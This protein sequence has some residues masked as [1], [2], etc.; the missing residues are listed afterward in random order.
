MNA[1]VLVDIPPST[2][3]QAKVIFY[4]NSPVSCS[5]NSKCF[6]IEPIGNSLP[7]R[8][9]N[10][11]T[12]GAC[13][14]FHRRSKSTLHHVSSVTVA[15]PPR[16]LSPQRPQRPYSPPFSQKNAAASCRS[17]LPAAC[18]ARD[19]LRWTWKMLVEQ[20]LPVQRVQIMVSCCFC[21]SSLFFSFLFF[22]VF[23]ISLNV[24]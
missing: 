24:F 2:L 22:S 23:S 19:E 16:I 7:S 6:G 4:P 3:L 17:S 12:L 9:E 15:S 8:K 5:R 10:L 14:N 1:S 11:F 20:A 13:A 18:C 21:C